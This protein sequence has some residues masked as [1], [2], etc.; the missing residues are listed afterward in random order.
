VAKYYY[1][2]PPIAGY[3]SKRPW[4][5]AA[6]RIVLIPVIACSYLMIFTGSFVKIIACTVLLLVAIFYSI[7]KYKLTT[8]TPR[9]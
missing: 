5:K 9:H 4:A 3:I 8:K 7:R 6:T 2:S 1:Y